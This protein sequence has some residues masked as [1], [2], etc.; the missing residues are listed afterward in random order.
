MLHTDLRRRCLTMYTSS[1]RIFYDYLANYTP[2]KL[3]QWHRA[4]IGRRHPIIDEQVSSRFIDAH[5]SSSS[6]RRSR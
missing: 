1:Y 3:S 6:S 5:R 4:L 2:I